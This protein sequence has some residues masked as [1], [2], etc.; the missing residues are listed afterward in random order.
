MRREE[1]PVSFKEFWDFLLHGAPQ[2][3]PEDKSDESSSDKSGESGEDNDE[4]EV[5]EENAV[6]E[7][8]GKNDK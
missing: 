8:D 3:A 7:D 4:R 6:K 5:I 1:D 2:M